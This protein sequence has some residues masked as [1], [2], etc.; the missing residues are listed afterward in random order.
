[1]A[2]L[3]LLFYRSFSP[4]LTVFSND[5]PLG[6]ISARSGAIPEA[7]SGVWSDLNWL[8]SHGISAAP[9]ITDV[10][11]WI[12]GP[13]LFSKVYAPVALFLLG[14]CTWFFFRQ[15]GLAPLACILGAVA[16]MLNTDALSNA[17]WGLCSWIIARAMIFL[18]LAFLV[19][20]NR[21]NRWINAALAGL[22]VG[23]NVSEG[24]DVGAICS[25]VVA[26]FVLF[27]GFIQSKPMELRVGAAFFR[28]ALVVILSGVM[29][30]QTISS[31]VGTQIKGVAGTQQDEATREQQWDF[32][33]QWSLPKLEVLRVIIPGLF[34]YRMDTPNGGNYWGNV[35]EQPGWESHHQGVRRYSGS[36]EYAGILV[37]MLALWAVVQAFAGAKSIFNPEH[38]KF[39]FF[40]ACVAVI[41][42]IFAFG[43]YAP[44][45][46]IIY[47]LPFFSTIRN[48]IKFMVPFHLGIVILFGYG[49]DGLARCCLGETKG[50]FLPIKAQIKSWWAA[51]ASRDRKWVAGLCAF[52]LL[53]CLGCLVFLSSH[54]ELEQYLGDPMRGGGFQPEQAKQMISYSSKELGWYLFFLLLSTG[55][56]IAVLSGWF[57]GTRAKMGAVLLGAILIADLARAN[58]P[59]VI[60]YNYK[61]KYTSNPI[62]DILKDKTY[63]HRVA[64]LPLD[65]KR[66]PPL[67]SLQQIYQVLWLQH[68]FPFYNVQ[69]I[70]I[71]QERG[72]GQDKTNF[73][74]ALIRSPA[75]YWE[76]TGAHYL[77]GLN[78]LVDLLNQQFDP[79]QQRFHVHTAFTMSQETADSP[80]EVQTNTAGPFALI[81]FTGALPRAG[82]YS[83]W[84][85]QTNDATTLQTIASP[86]FDPHKTVLIA[87]DVPP[88]QANAGTNASPGTVQITSYE[89]KRIQLKADNTTPAILLLNDR[90]DPDWHVSVDGKEQPLLRC[91]FIMRGVYLPP[92]SHM[93]EFKFTHSPAAL[94]V[95]CAALA[96]GAV[97]LLLFFLKPG[98][99]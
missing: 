70:D 12:T 21:G 51:A 52:V 44:F 43:R 3:L 9:N 84:E 96:V 27:Q 67:G 59:W 20:R 18:A 98:A 24:F 32:A 62:I 79:Q 57:S 25:L 2:V 31:L 93:V 41:G 61:E 78:G 37:V 11:V 80:I 88:P 26:A 40:W 17:A 65:P 94:W 8:G 82:L 81:E 99:P 56:V 35:G 34:G 91:D 92:G 15:L 10:L 38:R 13:V 77:L 86:A 29:A 16:S 45:Y 69:S 90:Y 75:R 5:G 50:K 28:L 95:S 60:Y 19:T 58:E 23:M 42:L 36:G 33:T 76:L 22:A 30:A 47:A 49:L 46:R 48:P 68:Q 72:I 1:V 63:E 74:N 89:P 97:L 54:G 14:I 55:A 85:V 87:N 6:A 39:I 7:F 4:D 53:S 64:I 71:P 83:H 66:F 73:V